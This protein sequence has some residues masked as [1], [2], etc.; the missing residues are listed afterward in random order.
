[1]PSRCHRSAPSAAPAILVTPAPA[2]LSHHD[3]KPTRAKLA[4]LALDKAYSAISIS[5]S[6]QSSDDWNLVV[7]Q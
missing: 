1:M 5:Q 2:N 6:A 3:V 7:S 4:E